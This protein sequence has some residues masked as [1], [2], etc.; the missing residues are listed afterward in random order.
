MTVF[1][2]CPEEQPQKAAKPAEGWTQEEEIMTKKWLLCLS[3]MMVALTSVTRVSAQTGPNGTD[4]RPFY[5][6]AHNPNTLEMVELALVSGANALEPDINVLPADAV[7]LPFFEKDPTGLVIYHDYVHL[8]ARVPLTLE[9]YFLGIHLLAEKYPQLALMVLDVK[10]DAAKQ[11]NGQ[12]ILDAIHTFLNFGDVNLNVVISVG[13]RT[14]SV[15]FTDIYSQLGE[16]EGVMVDAETDPTK[17]VNALGNAAN[18]NI[19]FADGTL[20]LGLDIP[21]AIDWGSFLRASWGVP[22]VIPD[23]STFQ[24]PGELG[25]YMESGA[26]GTIADHLPT[27]PPLPGLALAEFDPFSPPFVVANV[28]QLAMHPEVRYAFRSDNPFQPNVQA[29][30]LEVRTMDTPDGATDAPLDFTLEGCRGTSKLTFHTGTGP[31]LLGTGRMEAGQTDH[32]TIP[33]LNLGKLTKLTIHNQGGFFNRPNWDLQ[34]VNISSARYL[35]SDRDGTV[36]YQATFNGTIAADTTK[37]L[38]LT[39][40]FPEPE[41]TIECPLPITMNNAPGKCSAVVTFAPK[42]DGMCDDVTSTSVPASGSAFAV[43]TTSV[44]STAASPSFPQSSPMC[45]FSVTV[46]D[47]EAPLITCPAPMVVDAT[48]PLGVTVTFAPVAGDN[49][50]VT[51]SSA[52][53]SGSVF[54]IGTTAVTS[55]AQDPSGNQSSCSFTVHVKGAQEQLQDLITSV[56]NLAMSA[57]LKNALLAKLNAALAS[58]QSGGSTGPACGQLAAFIDLVSAQA[59]KDLAVSDADALIVLATKIRAVIGC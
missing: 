23:V 5:V 59:G 4:P 29:Y 18:S 43:G 38:T 48:S 54:A 9:E 25:F 41:P 49:C 17:V 28:G 57:G 7:S 53:A 31:D 58:V 1:S 8:T 24:I 15:L 35:G 45:T 50:S 42:V 19:G 3:T 32:V 40:N 47:V 16:R 34:D 13:T 6:V 37:T 21:K 26:D 30:G 27:V 56:N 14:D 39:P 20:G 10:P 52:P 36:E 55:T 51:V 46:K 22:K 33:S 11:E 44:T 2:N 12:K